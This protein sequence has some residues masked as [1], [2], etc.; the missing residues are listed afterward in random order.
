MLNL[1]NSKLREKLFVYYFT[2][3]HASHYL[4][5]LARMLKVDATNLSR[6]LAKLERQGIF[7]SQQKGAQKYFQLNKKSPIFKELKSIILKTVGVVGTLKESFKNLSEIDAA[8]LYGSFAAGKE[9][10]ASDIDVLVVGNISWDR[11]SEI[12][13]DLEDRLKREVNIKIYSPEEFSKKKKSDP[14][15]KSVLGSKYITL[16]GKL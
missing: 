14:F 1:R 5:E 9:D 11:T 2:N 13:T 16:F 15:L 4:R 8:V 12:I 7:I 6:E 10:E 3:L